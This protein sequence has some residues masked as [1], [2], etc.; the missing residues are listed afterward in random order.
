M[1]TDE[2]IGPMGSNAGSTG[3]ER[4]ADEYARLWE[5]GAAVPDVFAFLA[6]RR[7]AALGDRLE[8]LLIDQ[9]HRWLHGEPLPLRVYLSTFP[10]IAE[11]GEMIRALVDGER[12]QRSAPTRR[13]RPRRPIRPP[14]SRPTGSS[15]RGRGPRPRFVPRR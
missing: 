9:Q 3:T 13:R 14:G 4:P 10:E 5:P 8:V 12:Y 1:A 6:S 15:R 7:D 2:G 11:R